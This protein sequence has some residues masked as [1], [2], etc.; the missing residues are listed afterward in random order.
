MVAGILEATEQAEKIEAELIHFENVSL[1]PAGEAAV[2]SLRG[3]LLREG[4]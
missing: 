1:G 2:F 3:A 4:R